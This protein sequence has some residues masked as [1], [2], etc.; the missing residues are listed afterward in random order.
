MQRA[1]LDRKIDARW[2][3]IDMIAFDRHS[4]GGLQHFHGRMTA[5]QRHHHALM[6]RIEML[7][8]DEGHPAVG[9]KRGEQLGEGFEAA[10]RGSDSDHREVIVRKGNDFRQNAP[11]GPHLCGLWHARFRRH[12]L[13]SCLAHRSAERQDA[14]V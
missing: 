5:Q 3:D 11:A 1:V 6:R 12:F 13:L 14:Q 7:D 10:R 2:N 9:W 4:I 8:Q